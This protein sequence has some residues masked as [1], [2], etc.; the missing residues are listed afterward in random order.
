VHH[1]VH[2]T[3]KMIGEF[4]EDLFHADHRVWRTLKP[5]LFKPGLLTTEYLRGKRVTYTP[6]FRL[7]IVLSLIFF[8]FTS[9]SGSGVAVP[10]T[11]QT[12][13]A[14][15]APATDA[16]IDPAARQLME[17]LIARAP[18]A[19]RAQT[20]NHV[21]NALRDVPAA[22]QRDIVTSILT[23]CNSQALGWMLPAEGANRE[24]AL[25]ACRNVFADNGQ[26]FGTAF[27]HHVPH[28][29]FIF[30]PVIALWGKLLYIGS[31]RFYA[32]HL[33]FFVHF[34]AF[35]FLAITLGNGLEWIFGWFNGDWLSGLVNLV[36]TGYV[37]WYLYR[38]MR[39]VYG[40]SGLVTSLKF[41]L[42]TLF[43]LASLLLTLGGLV[44]FTALTLH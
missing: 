38:A 41:V 31:R 16:A 35:V 44:I 20:R 22:Q 17:Q 39:R 37:P 7:Y 8:L 26:R 10:T 2:S 24:R 43:Y 29:M 42:L 23:P 13:A 6:P 18:E 32:E 11:I 40:Q 28:M 15:P 9:L 5:L 27:W 30:L 19:Q 25:E 12:D 34:H 21:L 33:L 4:I 3:P 14:V 1:H 36:L